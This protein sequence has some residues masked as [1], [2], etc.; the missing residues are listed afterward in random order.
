MLKQEPYRLEGLEYYSTCLWHMKKQVEL[1][2]ISNYAFERSLNSPETWTILGNCYSLQKEHETALKYFSKAIQLDVYFSYAHT[3]SGH[4]YVDNEDFE[5]ARKCYQ[6]ALKADERHYN[7]WWGLG[8]IFHKQEK[9]EQAEFHFKR[10]TAIN[11]RAAILYSYLGMTHH[12]QNRLDEAIGNF[13]TAIAL[14]PHNSLNKYQKAQALRTAQRDQEALDLLLA[15]NQEV[16]KEA[17]IHIGIG[18]IYK[19]LGNYR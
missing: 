16:P 18:E 1:V 10:A 5:Q 4:E 6:E 14:D 17:P 2:Y 8:N 15:L 19:K 3:L 7:A 11:G 12:H 9:Y 13:D